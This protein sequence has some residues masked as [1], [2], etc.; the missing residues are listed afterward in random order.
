MRRTLLLA[1]TTV[2]LAIAASGCAF[3]PGSTS[4]DLEV[5]LAMHPQ[6]NATADVT[7]TNVSDHDVQLLS[8]YLPDAELQE[9]LFELSRDGQPVRYIGPIY[10]RA[11]PD[12]SDYVT[13]A[14]GASLTRTVNLAN[15]YD[16]STTGNYTVAVTLDNMRLRNTAGF[17]SAT[18]STHID[19]HPVVIQ[20]KPVRTTCTSAQLAEINA[21]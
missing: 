14:P 3:T 18:V 16:L 12:A 1:A 8:W 5:E 6:S 4:D 13:I 19:A 10:K 7:I 21:A 20:G 11:Q 9:P 17:I 2:I 15:F